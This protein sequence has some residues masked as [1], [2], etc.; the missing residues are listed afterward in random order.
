M[1][2]SRQEISRR[3]F[4]LIERDPILP[5]IPPTEPDGNLWPTGDPM[6]RAPTIRRL[7][8]HFPHLDE[9][10]AQQIR[11]LLHGTLKPTTFETVKAYAAR[12]YS[13]P[14]E[15]DLILEALNEIIEGHGTEPIGVEGVRIDRYFGNTAA[16]YVNTGDT[17]SA[18]IVYDTEQDRFELSTWGDYYELL[19]RR[20]RV[21]D[22]A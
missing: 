22:A 20:H 19:C 2:L 3:L 13:P 1:S 14:P 7:L 11:D 4:D 9:A 18:T 21:R 10:Q 6:Y 8:A 16:V 12:C 15:H 5:D 17:Y